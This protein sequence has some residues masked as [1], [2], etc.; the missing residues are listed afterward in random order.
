M[1]FLPSVKQSV[2]NKKRD[3]QCGF[4]DIRSHY[5]KS[6]E[7]PKIARPASWKAVSLKG[8]RRLLQLGCF[9]FSLPGC[10]WNKKRLQQDRGLCDRSG[11][12][13]EKE[14]QSWAAGSGWGATCI[15]TQNLANNSRGAAAGGERSK[16][17]KTDTPSVQVRESRWALDPVNPGGSLESCYGCILQAPSSVTPSLSSSTHRAY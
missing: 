12:K 1:G 16:H 4:Y 13:A 15:K 3:V 6:S 2:P 17:N 8:K 5:N 10:P 7:P 14:I 9:Y 11:Q